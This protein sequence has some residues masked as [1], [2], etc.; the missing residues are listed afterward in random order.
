MAICGNIAAFAHSPDIRM[1]TFPI[2][3]LAALLLGGCGGMNVWPFGG[4]KSAERPRTPANATEYQ[5]AGGKVF[6]LRMLDGA[7]WVIL[8]ERQFRLDPVAGSAGR[9]SN[10]RATLALGAETT[11]A[12][13]PAIDFKGCKLPA[14]GG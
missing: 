4:E 12:D 6:H 7:A 13:P 5:C 10:G 11:L 9:Y 14:A 2:P 1:R 3:I 8:P